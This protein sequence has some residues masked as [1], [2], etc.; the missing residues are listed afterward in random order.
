MSGGNEGALPGLGGE[1]DDTHDAP[2]EGTTKGKSNARL[3]VLVL[4]AMVAVAIVF[5]GAVLFLKHRR[6]KAAQAQGTGPVIM[7]DPTKQKNSAV[8]SKSIEALKTDIKREEAL[9]EGEEVGPADAYKAA[10]LKAAGGRPDAG[11]GKAKDGHGNAKAGQGGQAD[12][13][14]AGERV[15]TRRERQLA[16]SLAPGGLPPVKPEKTAPGAAQERS[17]APSPE[18]DPITRLQAVL[19]TQQG[20]AQ[21]A[22]SFPFGGGGRGAADADEAPAPRGTGLESQLTPTNLASV[23]AGRLGNL[24]F[25][26]K[27]NT[28]I[29]CAL[30]TGVDTTL[31]SFPVCQ[32]TND[33]YSANGKTLLI[34]RGATVH[35]EQ[36]SKMEQ[37]QATVFILWNRIDNPSGSYANLDSPAS[38]QMGYGGVAAEVNT[39]F[40]ARYGGALMLSMVSDGL[41]AVTERQQGSNGGSTVQ[42]G[43]TTGTTKDM[44]AEALKNSINI[45]PTGRVKPAKVISI[46]VARDVSFE[47]LFRIVQ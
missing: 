17:A 16:D 11:S 22:P 1:G 34:E 24:D 47:S 45:P 30:K 43:N 27:K 32:V 25:L 28:A 40:W 10:A 6:E 4:V 12:G 29:S 33:V 7:G 8:E 36:R 9:A 37:G 44:A 26:L 15:L 23:K 13:T 21:P 42:I 18:V 35:G 38:D 19:G 2:P 31:P 14:D 5:G 3:G 39:H 41:A 20:Q 46:I